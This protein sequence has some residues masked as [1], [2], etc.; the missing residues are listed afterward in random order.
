[1]RFYV[2]DDIALQVLARIEET[3]RAD[4]DLDLDYERAA[5]S[6]RRIVAD[7]RVLAQEGVVRLERQR[8]V[9]IP[10]I[11]GIHSRYGVSLP[12]ARHVWL[13]L[14]NDVPLLHANDRLR[15]RHGDLEHE[16]PELRLIFLPDYPL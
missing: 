2:S 8:P 6:A 13:A 10:L 15:E 11:W 7:F 3:V 4:P 9:E 1:M 14:R 5:V 16:L 12:D